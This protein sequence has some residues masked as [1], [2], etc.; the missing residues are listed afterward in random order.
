MMVKIAVVCVDKMID[1]NKRAAEDRILTQEDI[2]KIALRVLNKPL[3]IT[4]LPGGLANSIWCCEHS[5]L[6][7]IWTI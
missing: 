3:K 4:F 5:H 2:A 7:N 1:G 6:Q